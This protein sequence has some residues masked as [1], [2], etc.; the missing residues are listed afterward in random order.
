MTSWFLFQNTF[1]LRRPR[2]ASFTDIIKIANM[3]IKATFEDSN[4]VKKN[5]NYVL[6]WN[7]C[8]ISWYNSKVA[9]F[10]WQNA[11]VSRNQGG[12]TGFIFFLCVL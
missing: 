9:N 5:R 1:T 10:W 4:E 12:V 2:V 7:L 3:F 11:D 6:K 8:C